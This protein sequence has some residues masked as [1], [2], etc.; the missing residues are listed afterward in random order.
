MYI[1]VRGERYKQGSLNDIVGLRITCPTEVDCGASA[2]D[3]RLDYY[4]R[5]KV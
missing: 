1:I 2:D 5:A 4:L 3:Q